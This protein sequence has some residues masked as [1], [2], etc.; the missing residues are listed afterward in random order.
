[1]FLVYIKLAYSKV[2]PYLW[3]IIKHTTNIC[4]YLDINLVWYNISYIS[5][6]DYTFNN[7]NKNYIDSSS[8]IFVLY[9]FYTVFNPLYKSLP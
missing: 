6:I 9:N 4:I 2:I 5:Y 8:D 7:S 3:E 1:M